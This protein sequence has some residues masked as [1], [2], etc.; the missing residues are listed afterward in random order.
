VS[1]QSGA[2]LA[3]RLFASVGPT[4]AVTLRLVLGAVVLVALAR[5]AVW[6][7]QRGD[8]VA[9]AGFGVALALMN[10]SF[11]EAIDR[12]PLGVAVTVEFVGPLAVALVGSRRVLDGV[13]ALL[14]GAGVV[15]LGAD[16]GGHLDA[17]GVALA[18]L[19]GALWAGY[20]LLSREVGRRVD[21]IGGL[22]GA[23]VVASLVVAPA[24]VA[25]G[26]RRLLGPGVLG[27]GT[28]VALLSSVIPYSLELI[29]LRRT[30]ARAFGVL[31]SM[32]PAIAAL[33]G[34]VVLGQHLAGSELAALG[35]V[36]SANLGSALTP[37]RSAAA[38]L[39]PQ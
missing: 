37:G 33:A 32:D 17:T 21:G 20:I 38:D 25:T 18:L 34:L 3:T 30:S 11:Y 26:G 13:W 12:I 14:A 16:P 4:G 36:V 19:A 10:L 39:P 2:A 28:A 29:A 7:W 23:M 15:L 22:A 6:R 9:V 8:W 31:L 27:R 1:V 24:G 5:P 35:L